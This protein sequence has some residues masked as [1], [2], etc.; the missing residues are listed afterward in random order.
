MLALVK[1]LKA[2]K[3]QAN[4]F[5]TQTGKELSYDKYSTLVTSSAINH[6][7]QFQLK[8]S[9]PSKKVYYHK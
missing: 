7:I 3:D 6:D 2:V 5:K 4:Q 8:S 9:K 1:A